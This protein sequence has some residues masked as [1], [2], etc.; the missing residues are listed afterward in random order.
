MVV[1]VSISFGSACSNHASIAFSRFSD[2][3]LMRASPEVHEDSENGWK[4][5]FELSGKG[6]VMVPLWR[7]ATRSVAEFE[8][9]I[10]DDGSI[11]NTLVIGGLPHELPDLN[12][13]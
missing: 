4:R 3:R 6:G 11:G 13:G 8:F 9:W 10:G 12:V 5:W 1:Q 7:V 2:S